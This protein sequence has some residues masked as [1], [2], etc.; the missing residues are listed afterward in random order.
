MIIHRDMS[1][2]PST[3]RSKDTME[4]EPSTGFS[5]NEELFGLDVKLCKSPEVF[6]LTKEALSDIHVRNCSSGSS[7]IESYRVV[8]ESSSSPS[9][10]SYSSETASQSEDLQSP[11]CLLDIQKK[12]LSRSMS[13]S[14]RDQ[15]R[16]VTDSQTGVV[17]R[18]TVGAIPIMP[19][20]KVV[21]VSSSRAD[22]WILPKG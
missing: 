6:V 19:S 10:P 5:M 2:P 11:Q 20:G 22:G 7:N 14:G 8:S 17:Y 18:L 13:R 3:K 21:L 9:A 16:F 12:I 1:C 15:Q 4:T